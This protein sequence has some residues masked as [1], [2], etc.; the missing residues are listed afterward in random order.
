MSDAQIMSGTRMIDYYE[1]DLVMIVIVKKYEKT[2]ILIY[3]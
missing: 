1:L 3:Q 2:N